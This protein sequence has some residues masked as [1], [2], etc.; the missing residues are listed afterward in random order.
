[1]DALNPGDRDYSSKKS[2]I[3]GIL[4]LEKSMY[5]IFSDNGKTLTYYCDRE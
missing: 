4:P 1:M 5:A 2:A 3:V